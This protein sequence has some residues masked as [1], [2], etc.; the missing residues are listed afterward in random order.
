MQWRAGTVVEQVRH[1]PGAVEL[2]VDLDDGA[3]PGPGAGLHG[4]D[5]RARRRAS[6]C[7]STPPRCCGGSARAGSRSSSPAPTCCRPTPRPDPGTSSRRATPRCSRCSSPSTSRTR[8]HH[9]VLAEA[10]DLDGLPVVVADLHSALPAVLAGVR[11]GATGGPG[12]LRDDRRRSAARRVLAGRRRPAR[13]GL[14]R[15]LPHGRAGLRRRP[16]GRHRAHGPARRPPRRG[17]RRRRRGPGAGQRRHRDPV[18]LLG[19]RRRRGA[20]RRGRPRGARHRRA[21]GLRG[22]PRDRG[23]AASAT[24][25]A[26]PTVAPC[27]PPARC[28]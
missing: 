25:A 28:R 19:G 13:G 2:A 18:G 15:R 5:R 23:T 24:T 17:G 3:G 4:G 6:G 9:G 26:P 22:R 11:H 20:A 21:A 1:W 12:G 10:D 8:P 14:A 16:R 7:C 27:S